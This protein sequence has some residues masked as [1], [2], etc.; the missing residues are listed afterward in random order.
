MESGCEGIFKE[1]VFRQEN[2]EDIKRTGLLYPSSVFSIMDS[3][4]HFHI[5]MK[6]GKRFYN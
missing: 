2:D 1:D 6:K 4:K 5:N 3:N